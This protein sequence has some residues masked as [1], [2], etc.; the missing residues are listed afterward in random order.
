MKE[1]KFRVWDRDHFD[2]LTLS[3]I[4]HYKDMFQSHILEGKTFEQ[5]TGIKDKNGVEIY[6]GDKFMDSYNGCPFILMVVYNEKAC[7]FGVNYYDGVEVDE[8][9]FCEFLTMEDYN[10]DEMEII[11]NIHE[12]QD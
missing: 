10:F 2:Y 8:N 3:N 5:Y 6:E 4:I 1:I 12:K 7:M 11:G 9:A